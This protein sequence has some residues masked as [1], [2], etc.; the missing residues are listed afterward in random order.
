MN[1]NQLKRGFTR[2]NPER[3]LHAL[4]G[5]QKT[6]H[7]DPTDTTVRVKG[8]YI[9]GDTDR[10]GRFFGITGFISAWIYAILLPCS[11]FF[12]IRLGW[13]E[14]GPFA[15]FLTGFTLIHG[16]AM[17]ADGLRPSGTPWARRGIKTF[18]ITSLAFF[19]LGVVWA[20][21]TA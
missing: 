10:T 16:C 3:S 14:F 17:F 11:A 2:T 9:S 13:L 12:E 8:R 15:V 7:H 1:L 18:W 21:C 20:I 19:F 5:A 6:E 4:P